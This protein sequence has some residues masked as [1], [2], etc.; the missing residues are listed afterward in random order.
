MLQTRV[1]P[2]L[3]LKN[4]GLV[5]TRQFKNETYIGDS[6]NAV[7]IFNEKEV[8]ELIFL[9]ITASKEKK[10]PNFDLIEQIA[11]ECFMPFAYGG[12]INDIETSQRLLNLGIEKLV[13]NSL[14]FKSL[15]TVRN[16]TECFGSQS[17]IASIDIKKNLWGTPQ[18][19]SHAGYEVPIKDPVEWAKKL[20]DTGVGE[21]MV[22]SVD[23]DGMMTGYDLEIIRK[24][25][26]TVSVPVIACGG[27]A[28]PDD[29]RKASKQAG[30]SA[31]AAGSMFVFHGKH[32]AVLINFPDSKQL[33]K[34]LT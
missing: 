8:D 29:L 6:I 4:K 14:L 10:I 1:I 34:I 27:A 5:K 7:R 17:V 3:L 19:Y 20:V 15:D 13:L 25:T 30:A 12:G 32:R 28:T 18:V 21:I 9:D 2:V 22:Y 24:I 31:V 26:S 33:E 11:T 23:K 16:M